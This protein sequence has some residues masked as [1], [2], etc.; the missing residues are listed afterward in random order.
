LVRRRTDTEGLFTFWRYA[1]WRDAREGPRRSGPPSPPTCRC[2]AEATLSVPGVVISMSPDAGR[3]HGRRPTSGSRSTTGNPSQACGRA[4]LTGW[5]L[6]T[7]LSYHGLRRRF[8]VTIDEH[9]RL[10][11]DP[12]SP[13]PTTSRSDRAPWRRRASTAST[14]RPSASWPSR[15]PPRG[16]AWFPN[17]QWVDSCLWSSSAAGSVS[18]TTRLREVRQILT[19]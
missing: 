19:V 16:R 18:P 15:C 4:P 12:R 11:E 13:T 10:P 9:G 7:P 8:R 2:S 17:G 14:S 1:T 5:L 3:H 6:A